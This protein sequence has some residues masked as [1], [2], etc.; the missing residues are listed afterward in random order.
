MI[1]NGMITCIHQI[2]YKEIRDY[3]ILDNAEVG[4]ETYTIKIC[5]YGLPV[6]TG[7]SDYLQQNIDPILARSLRI[8]S[9]A[10][11]YLLL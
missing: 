10:R 4:L 11:Y 8:L 1:S 3:I 9:R 7:L 2:T 5:K 6:W